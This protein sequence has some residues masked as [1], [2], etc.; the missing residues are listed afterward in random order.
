MIAHPPC[1][2]I[3]RIYE[4]VTPDT[5]SARIL[6]DRLWPR[7]VSKDHARLDLWAKEWAPSEELRHF[8]HDHPERYAEFSDRYEKE[9]ELQKHA[10]RKTIASFH[11]KKIVL[12]YASANIRENNAQVLRDLLT[13]WEND[14]KIRSADS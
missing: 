12:L 13:R 10:I 5:G 4:D 8:F 14:E 3:Q 1:F 9:L 7:G 11:P 2:S 6:V